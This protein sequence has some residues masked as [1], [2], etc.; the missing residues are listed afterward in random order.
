LFEFT[1]YGHRELLIIYNSLSTTDPAAPNDIFTT[2]EECKKYKIRISIICVVA[3]IYICKKIAEV[4]GT[5]FISIH[6]LFLPLI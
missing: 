1:D 4:T 6:H 5:A 2:L 3:E